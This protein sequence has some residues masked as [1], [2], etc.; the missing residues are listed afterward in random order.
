MRERLVGRGNAFDQHLD[1]AAAQLV[2]VEPGL[3]DP[4]VIENQQI[5]GLEQVFD[6]REAF[7]VQSSLPVDVQQPAARAL[8]RRRLG[9]QLRWQHVVEIG[10]GQGVGHVGAGQEAGQVQMVCAGGDTDRASDLVTPSRLQEG[11]F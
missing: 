3:D 11:A 1:F 9:D 7:V 2:A 6:R 4:G 5:A 8:G 10:E